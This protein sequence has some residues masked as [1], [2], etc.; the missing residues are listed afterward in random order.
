MFPRMFHTVTSDKIL[1]L[2]VPRFLRYL[3]GKDDI[4]GNLQY[5][6]SGSVSS[7][8]SFMLRLL[9][10]SWVMVTGTPLHRQTHTENITFPQ[11]RWRA[12]N[13]KGIKKI[14]E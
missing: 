11:L 13:V 4:L 2:Q 8:E 3:S 14:G 6:V 10:T 7:D 5:K 12:V 1:M 9:M